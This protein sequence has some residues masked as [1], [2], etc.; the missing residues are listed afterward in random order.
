MIG[1]TYKV[2]D[3]GHV[4]VIDVMGNDDAIV[5]AARVSYGAGTKTKREDE[6]LIKYLINHSHVSPLEHCSIKLHLKMPIFV[7]RQWSKHNGKKNEVS[8]RY[9]ELPDE[10]YIPS[11]DNIGPQST[12][13][14]QGRD[15]LGFSDEDKKLI[16]RQIESV[17][18]VAYN[19]YEDMLHRGLSRELA[20]I[21]LPVGIYTEYYW[22]TN[23]RDL[24]FLLKSRLH[25]T[26]QDEVREYAKVISENI[27]TQWCPVAWEAFKEKEGF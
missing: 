6:K 19:T 14:K 8:A 15:K 24:C 4:R 23:L 25:G 22:T 10:F 12:A 17:Y 7:D 3:K 5:Q 27:M 18:D 16:S 13:N 20:R 9:S 11:I 21:V 26:A 1:E 2:L